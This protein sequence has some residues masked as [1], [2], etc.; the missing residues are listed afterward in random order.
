MFRL[1]IWVWLTLFSAMA[2]LY[3]ARAHLAFPRLPSMKREPPI[4]HA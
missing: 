2:S 3:E 4:T 1:F